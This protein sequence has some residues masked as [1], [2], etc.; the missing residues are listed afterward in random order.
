MIFSNQRPT[1]FRLQKEFSK[2]KSARSSFSIIKEVIEANSA[3]YNRRWH[4][5]LLLW[6]R[7]LHFQTS[8]SPGTS[9][10]V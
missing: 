9:S 3:N 7:S 1:D 6:K 5:K 4:I 8:G 10:A 2:N